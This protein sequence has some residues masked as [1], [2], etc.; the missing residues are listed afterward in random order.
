MNSQRAILIAGP[1]AAGKSALALE[2]AQRHSGVIVNA[3]SMQVYRELRVLTARPSDGEAA[4]AP[5]ALYGH[6]PGNIAYSVGLWLQDAT[7]VLAAAWAEG[8]TPIVVGGTG[9][10]FK[11][12][13]EGLA[14]IPEIPEPVRTHW[15]ETAVRLGAAGL[16]RLLAERDPAMAARLRPGDTQ[17]LTR[18]LEVLAATGRS[19]ADWQR[20]AGRP[21][22]READTERYVL[23]PDRATVHARADA[24]FDAMMAAGAL[25]EVRRLAALGLPRDLPVMR[26]LGVAPLLDVLAGGLDLQTAVAQ[27][28]LDTRRYIKRQ[29]TWLKRNMITWKAIL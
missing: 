21:L 9:L 15:R 10:Y 28:K 5:H 20:E 14:P 1:T 6:V 16:H 19:L 13:L 12:L 4:A 3:D 27:A 24:R 7:A 8:R 25:D 23:A 22:L 18:A 11:A 29:Q 17:R 26:A 2:L